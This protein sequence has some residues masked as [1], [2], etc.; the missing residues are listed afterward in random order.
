[1]AGEWETVTKDDGW[2]DLPP[3]VAPA[4][5]SPMS[6][7][8]STKSYRGP[9][10]YN[11]LVHTGKMMTDL[12]SGIKQ[13]T[14]KNDN[15]YSVQAQKDADIY[16]KY[17]QPLSAQ[18]AGGALMMLPELLASPMS[19]PIT[20]LPYAAL[21]K[22]FAG[23]KGISALAKEI[24][25]EAATKTRLDL[26]PGV[27][28]GLEGAAYGAASHV[29][30]ASE[31]PGMDRFKN[32][33]IGGASGAALDA[34]IS[35]F[36]TD[37]SLRQAHKAR[38]DISGDLPIPVRLPGPS[39]WNQ[40]ARGAKAKAY[41]EAGSD[42]TWDEGQSTKRLYESGYGDS[43]RDIEDNVDI[44]RGEMTNQTKAVPKGES[45]SAML[46]ELEVG[47]EQSKTTAND[48]MTNF[49]KGDNTL[50]VDAKEFYDVADEFTDYLKY[51][52][53][54]K[55]GVRLGELR[56]TVDN[57]YDKIKGGFVTAQ[58]FELFRRTT[59]NVIKNTNPG[60]TDG[61]AATK[62]HSLI[63]DK[64]D[65]FELGTNTYGDQKSFGAF[66][67]ARDARNTYNTA[68][69]QNRIIREAA[70]GEMSANQLSDELFGAK[71]MQ[72]SG[73]RLGA[74][75]TLLGISPKYKKDLK[76]ESFQQL[77][78]GQSTK[79]KE[80]NIQEFISEYG[81]GLDTGR[82]LPTFNK[83]YSKEELG[84]FN[85]LYN[86]SRKLEMKQPA[87]ASEGYAKASGPAQVATFNIIP[88][89]GNML[90]VPGMRQMVGK[91]L[92]DYLNALRYK[93]G[94]KNA[95]GNSLTGG[96]T[97]G[98]AIPSITQDTTEEMQS[99]EETQLDKLLKLLGIFTTS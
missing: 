15:P 66:T 45:L 7:T 53:P 62:L 94:R 60:S 81:G 49:L 89:A 75:D 76:R 58:D 54:G 35:G 50:S 32:T 21:T 64:M 77:T 18:I 80:F 42:L 55:E 88:S 90:N 57:M 44:L 43:L 46:K 97:G 40:K 79:G 85:D 14:G 27:G 20:A 87:K 10:T 82:G 91:P 65:N 48:K 71:N 6:H 17:D 70:D 73:E 86:V 19:L 9:G 63:K 29:N 16:G 68:Y 13:L 78:S 96:K 51:Q 1:M 3:G 69:N 84:K 28:G 98:T 22:P 2:E 4:K 36:R 26:P 11:P 92:E 72:D 83:L 39:L 59:N 23:G 8:G 37:A 93:T 24:A 99:T 67:E 47:K 31:T 56:D 41:R 52:V 5:K 30:P 12:I 95:V 61:A 74:I 38:S 33:L 34:A 25:E